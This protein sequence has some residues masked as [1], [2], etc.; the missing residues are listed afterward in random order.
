MKKNLFLI[1][2]L[3]FIN[4]QAQVDDL[5]LVLDK[6]KLGVGCNLDGA[7]EIWM[8]SGVC[9]SD[10]VACNSF[11][12][13]V[14]ENMASVDW[15]TSSG[16][17]NFTFVDSSDG[18]YYLT[19]NNIASHYGS[20]TPVYS[21]GLIFRDSTGTMLGQDPNC[22]DILIS[23]IQDENPQVFQS[24]GTT[25]FDGVMVTN[26]LN[27]QDEQ[28]FNLVSIY[29]NPFNDFFSISFSHHHQSKT[30][31]GASIDLSLFNIMGQK[32]DIIYEGNL[33]PGVHKIDWNS[34]HYDSGIYFIC[35]KTESFTKTIKVVKR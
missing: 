30:Y 26:P 34:E 19:L 11:S 9:T 28:Q 25:I 3:T 4:T 24:D 31:G 33:N 2:A 15:G 18:L 5:Y 12:I 35:F 1:L 16:Y 27:I 29:P 8:H 20:S 14:W 22:G 10:S 21:M 13:N 6:S 17:E 7:A 32:I 23:N